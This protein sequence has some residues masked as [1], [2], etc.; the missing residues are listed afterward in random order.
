[1]VLIQAPN[2]FFIKKVILIVKCNCML[3]VVYSYNNVYLS[4]DVCWKHIGGS[5]PLQDVRH[6]RIGCGEK[7]RGTNSRHASSVST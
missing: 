7:V 4:T 5:E 6:V 1:M 3:V 2:I